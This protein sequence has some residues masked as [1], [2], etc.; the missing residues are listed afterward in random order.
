MSD[1]EEFQTCPRCKVDWAWEDNYMLKRCLNKC[2]FQINSY[3]KELNKVTV[4]SVMLIIEGAIYKYYIQWYSKDVCRI[5]I[6]ENNN[7]YHRKSIMIPNINYNLK[8]EGDLQK[9]LVLL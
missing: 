5:S 9:Y 4:S 1:L 2:G 6:Y 8:T 7:L 3:N